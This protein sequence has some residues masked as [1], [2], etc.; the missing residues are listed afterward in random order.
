MKRY[1]FILGLS[2]LFTH[3]LDAIL[4]YEW[5]LLPLINLFLDETGARVFV[6]AHIPLFAVVL[7]LITSRKEQIRKRTE[8]VLSIFMVVHGVLH[9]F[10]I[11]SSSYEFWSVLSN[12]LIFGGAICGMVYLLLN[13]KSRQYW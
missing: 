13:I 11:G 6:V 12:S 4:N 7:G 3:E 1:V 2:L 10:F 9:V 8:T 5:R